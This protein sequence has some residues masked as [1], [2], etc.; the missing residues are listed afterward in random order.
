M[1]RRTQK[2]IWGRKGDAR[3]RGGESSSAS[4]GVTRGRGTGQHARMY[5]Y[6]VI[7]GEQ[8]LDSDET[9]LPSPFRINASS[10]LTRLD[11][12]E[13]ACL[14]RPVVT[15]IFLIHQPRIA[16]VSSARPTALQEGGSSSRLVAPPSP[17]TFHS[18]PPVT[19]ISVRP[20]SLHSVSYTAVSHQ[21]Q[22][23]KVEGKHRPRAEPAAHPHADLGG[24]LA[25]KRPRAVGGYRPHGGDGGKRVLHLPFPM[26][27]A[28]ACALDK[29]AAV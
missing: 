6:N 10:S 5:Q 19:N 23:V 17:V 26:F 11:A 20:C 18:P 21:P 12:C 2:G 3:G 24:L 15:V 25:Q 1:R 22:P 27:G 13:P 29:R 28:D 9:A 4:H 8:S 7:L 14:H 16:P